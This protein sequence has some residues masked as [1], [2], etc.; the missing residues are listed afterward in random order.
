[1][2]LLYEVL[3]L[4]RP[5]RKAVDPRDLNGEDIALRG[6][7]FTVTNHGDWLTVTDVLA[8]RQSVEREA[9][10]GPGEMPRRPEWGMGLREELLRGSSIDSKNRQATSVRRRLGVNPRISSVKRVSVENRADLTTTGNVAVVT[11]EAESAGRSL[12]ITTIV[13]PR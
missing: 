11:I 9:C 7:D 10:A 4:P 1:M 13:K 6:A 12:P 8:A 3:Q 5:N 2:P